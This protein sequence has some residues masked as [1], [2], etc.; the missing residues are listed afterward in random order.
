MDFLFCSVER[1]LQSNPERYPAVGE[2][3]WVWSSRDSNT[4]VSPIFRADTMLIG[5]PFNLQKHQLSNVYQK[6]GTDPVF[7]SLW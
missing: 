2:I 5:N 7:L 1:E 4:Y 3:E 6:Q